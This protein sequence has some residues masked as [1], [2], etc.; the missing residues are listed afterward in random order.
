MYGD[1]TFAGVYGQHLVHSEEMP[2]FKDDYP[3]PLA[4]TYLA[5]WSMEIFGRN[6]FAVR[7]PSIILGLS[8][9][10][11]FIYCLDF[12]SEQK[13]RLSHLSFCIFISAF[14]DMET[15]IRDRRECI[16]PDSCAYFSLLIL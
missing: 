7:F 5:G 3:H 8:V 9:R 13:L 12:C 2:P 1:E 10:S 6:V 15:I 14:R 11:Q 16:F 4:H